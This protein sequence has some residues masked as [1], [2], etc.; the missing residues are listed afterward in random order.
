M[1]QPSALPLDSVQL[2]VKRELDA[3]NSLIKN[4]LTSD[5][6][7]VSQVAEH[8]IH[9]GGKRIRPLVALLSAKAINPQPSESAISAAVVIEFIHSATLLHDDVVDGSDQRRGKDTANTVFGNAASVLVGDFLYS[10]AFQIMVRMND[11]NIMHV[12]ADA[13]NLIAEGEVMQLMLSHDPHL[14]EEQYREV[15]YRKTARLFEAGAH[16][17]AITSNA[18]EQQQQ[19]LARFG[20]HLGCAFQLIDDVL[21]YTGSADQL[22]KSVGDDLA[23][24]KLTLPLIHALRTLSG[25]DRDRLVSAIEAQGREDLPWVINAIESSGALLY[26]R[27]LAE[28]EIRSAKAALDDL[29]NSEAKTALLLL[30][31]FAINRRF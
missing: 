15:I 28:K 12:M 18:S 25:A 17:A 13:T 16:I 29:A 6:P 26:T 19:A 22:G 5:V 4:E 20:K 2:V 3:A 8:L 10:R 30:A 23:E 31:D 14:T 11:L 24:G 7:L 27:A 9:S 1:S 21:D